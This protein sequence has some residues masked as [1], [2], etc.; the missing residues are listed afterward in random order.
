MNDVTRA[1]REAAAKV[2]LDAYEPQI[3][4]ASHA[5][6]ASE[7]DSLRHGVMLWFMA[8][9][10]SVDPTIDSEGWFASFGNTPTERTILLLLFRLRDT[11]MPEHFR[12]IGDAAI[13]RVS[14]ALQNRILELTTP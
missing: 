10:E 13:E 6:D 12:T 2:F 4:K 11:I 1:A 7:M 3:Q 8:L 14:L 5:L 9:L